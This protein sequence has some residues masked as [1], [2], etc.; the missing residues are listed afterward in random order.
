MTQ[1]ADER[2]MRLAIEKTR[3]GVM[4]GQFPF[5]AC[6]VRNDEILACV[7][8]TVRTAHDITCHAEI[9]A[10]REACRAAG[11]PD[12]SGSVLYA[13]ATPCAMCFTAAELA[14]IERVVI[15]VGP[16]DFRKI[17]PATSRPLTFQTQTGKAASGMKVEAGLLRE[18]CLSMFELWAER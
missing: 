15:G 4:A 9:D 10:I 11:S 12:L 6:L 8:N 17:F 1:E 2:F 3:E 14:G 16:G 13:T 7:H 18:A 5:G